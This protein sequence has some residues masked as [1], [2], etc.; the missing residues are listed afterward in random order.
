MRLAI[1]G[2]AIGMSVN[3][4]STYGIFTPNFDMMASTFWNAPYQVGRVAVAP[5]MPR[6]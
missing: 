1:V 5:G 3:A 4:L 6:C 2:Y